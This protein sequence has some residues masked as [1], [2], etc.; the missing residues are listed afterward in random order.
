[1]VAFCMAGLTGLSVDCNHI[2]QAAAI[3]NTERTHKKGLILRSIQAKCAHSVI[4][5]SRQTKTMVEIFEG[6]NESTVYN[7]IHSDV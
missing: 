1:M 5:I 7:D 2:T 3:L 6:L 4:R